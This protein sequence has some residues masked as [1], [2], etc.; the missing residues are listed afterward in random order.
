MTRCHLVRAVARR[1]ERRFAQLAAGDDEINAASGIY[2]NRLSDLC[3]VTAR[4]L[5]KARGEPEV[6]WEQ[7]K[8]EADAG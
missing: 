4:W 2:L 5:A 8:P 7:Q 6:L 3:F 1:A